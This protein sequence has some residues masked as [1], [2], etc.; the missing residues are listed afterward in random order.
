MPSP[1]RRS[2]HAIVTTNHAYPPR[3]ESMPPTDWRRRFR[4]A[5]MVFARRRLRL[6][7]TAKGIE[8]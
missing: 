8:R 5:K 2:R 3:R 7:Q 4:W 1:L 6:C